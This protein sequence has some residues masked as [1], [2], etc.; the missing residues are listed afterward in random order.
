MNSH[1]HFCP[2]EFLFLDESPKMCPWKFTQEDVHWKCPLEFAHFEYSDPHDFSGKDS[3][4]E[5]GQ[6]AL[7]Y[8][9]RIDN[10]IFH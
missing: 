2:K 6:E 7:Q 5:Q 10:G 9:W 8:I 1:G 4:V 3:Q